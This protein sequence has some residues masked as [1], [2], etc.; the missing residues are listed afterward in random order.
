MPFEA[1]SCAPFFWGQLPGMFSNVIFPKVA[2]LLIYFFPHVFKH[3]VLTARRGLVLH[4]F[5]WTTKKC[6]TRTKQQEE[7]PER[8]EPSGEGG[9][10]GHLRREVTF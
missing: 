3:M 8:R 4:T 1:F 10:C 6:T 7:T 5:T 9:C 2:S